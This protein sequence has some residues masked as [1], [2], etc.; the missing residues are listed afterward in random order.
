MNI[1]IFCSYV[2]AWGKQF[3]LWAIEYSKVISY[4][5]MFY[6]VYSKS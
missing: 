5:F 2:Y 1:T 3:I 6:I 4:R